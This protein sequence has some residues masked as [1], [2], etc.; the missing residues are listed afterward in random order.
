MRFRTVL[1]CLLL[2]A[3]TLTGLIADPINLSVELGVPSIVQGDSVNVAIAISGLVDHA[4]PSL[5]AYELA[6]TYDPLVLAHPVVTFGD[7]VLGDQLALTFPSFKCVGPAC[8]LS[9][10]PLLMFELSFDSSET[11]N[12]SQ[13]GAFDL[14]TVHFDGIGVGSSPIKLS[15]ILLVDSDGNDLR[16]SN[17]INISDSLI[18][19]NPVVQG[20]V[21]E[22]GSLLLFASTLVVLAALRRSRFKAKCLIEHR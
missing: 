4:A 12:T 21:P 18:T 19:V 11:L 9:S 14:L 20:Q 15:H 10:M 16:Q 7:P 1:A 5:A 17:Q 3:S 13:P 22:P 6:I 8:G 2:G